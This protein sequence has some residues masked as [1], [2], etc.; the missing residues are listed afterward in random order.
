M[1]GM[2]EM[3][4][5]SRRQ[6]QWQGRRPTS[7]PPLEA[8]RQTDKIM[9]DLSDGFRREFVLRNLETNMV[10]TVIFS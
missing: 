6:C 1:S 2:T 9:D 5:T 7:I 10:V 3:T 8:P 4:R